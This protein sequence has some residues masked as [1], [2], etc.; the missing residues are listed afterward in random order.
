MRFLMPVVLAASLAFSSIAAAA[1]PTSDEMVAMLKVI[2]DRQ[3]NNGDYKSLV[4]LETKEKD[5]SDLVYQV[6]VYRRDELDKLV[7]MFL[8]PASE[9]GK[10]YLRVDNSLFLYDP[11]VGKWER[12]T[13]RE[14]IGGTDSNRQDFDQ[15][16]LHEEYTPSFVAEEKLGNFTTY[17]IRLDAKEGVDVAYPVLN[18]WIDEPTGNVL[19]RQDLALSERLM[20]TTYYPE[21]QKLFSESKGADVYFPKEI[22]IFDEVEK[23]NQTTIVIQE[24]DLHTLDDSIFTKAWLESKSR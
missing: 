14:R 10:G 24:V 19:K 8:K 23:G 3:E 11:T 12:R 21:W 5:K 20:R 6:V 13:E 9:A 2:D 1:T 7:I 18:L 17:H 22:R 15:S 16:R 4:Y